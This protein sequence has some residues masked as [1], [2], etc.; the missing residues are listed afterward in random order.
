MLF[1]SVDYAL[2]VDGMVQQYTGH[3]SGG[4]P[5][6][7]RPQLP[8][9]EPPEGRF[10][11]DEPPEQPDGQQRQDGKPQNGDFQPPELPDGEQPDGAFTL[12]DEIRS[13][14]NITG[15]P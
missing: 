4:F 1:R 10:P 12:T 11:D 7:G 15:Q 9:G 3:G 5:G 6:G 14:S 2:T 8:D 13:F